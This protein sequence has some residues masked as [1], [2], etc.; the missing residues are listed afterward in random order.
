MRK[1]PG[2]RAGG[3][4]KAAMQDSDCTLSNETHWPFC[5]VLPDVF[6][7]SDF[8]PKFKIPE[9]PLSRRHYTPSHFDEA[10]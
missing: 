5:Q 6:D 9:M 4:K 3:Q 7:D 2:P 1:E 10:S 8:E